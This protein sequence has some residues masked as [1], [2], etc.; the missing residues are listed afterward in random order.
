MAFRLRKWALPRCE[1]LPAITASWRIFYRGICDADKPARRD[2]DSAAI[3]DHLRARVEGVDMRL[4]SVLH[5]W[6]CMAHSSTKTST[7]PDAPCSRRRPAFSRRRAHPCASRS[8]RSSALPNALPGPSSDS[9]GGPFP[10]W[11]SENLSVRARGLSTLRSAKKNHAQGCCP[12]SLG[13]T[14]PQM[15]QHSGA[16]GQPDARTPERR[17]RA[18]PA[19]PGHHRDRASGEGGAPPARCVHAGASSVTCG[20]APTG[21][22]GSAETAPGLDVP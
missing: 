14:Q 21:G 10:F 3:L 13:R 1:S 7:A 18:V 22:L 8:R 15:H 17:P 16:S 4:F 12:V 5:L 19:T 6:T 9:F 2:I 20:G 11:P